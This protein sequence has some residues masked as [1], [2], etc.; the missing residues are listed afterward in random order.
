MINRRYP[1]WY[2][3]GNAIVWTGRR[4]STSPRICRITGKSDARANFDAAWRSAARRR[5][6]QRPAALRH[7]LACAVESPRLRGRQLARFAP[8]RLTGASRD[9]L[10]SR[11]SPRS[12]GSPSRISAPRTASAGRMLLAAVVAIELAV[13]GINVLINQWNARFYNALQDRNWDSFVSELLFFCLLA[14]TFIVLAV[15]QL[16]LNQWLQIRWRRFLTGALSRRM[17]RRGQPLPHAAARRCRRQ[18][19]PA[20]RRG[21]QAV[22]RRRLERLGILPIGLGLLNAVVSL[23]SFVVI[24]WGLSAGRPAHA[25]RRAVEHPGLSGLGGADLCDRRHRCS[26]T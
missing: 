7:A 16:Y 12:G 22:H 25:V 15:Y 11:R 21:H 24:L 1:G 23:G 5:P 13:V 3:S 2:S 8:R 6:R 17:A 26:P 10:P 19:G 18:P 20:Y 9:R 14:G 4:Y